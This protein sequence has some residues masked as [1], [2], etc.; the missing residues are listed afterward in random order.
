MNISNSLQK[1][2]KTFAKKLQVSV[3]KILIFF[4]SI[5]MCI[6]IFVSFIS[7]GYATFNIIIFI[8]AVIIEIFGFIRMYKYFN[9]IDIKYNT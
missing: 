5:S 2:I 3:L 1:N 6:A 8:V 4:I 7:S 9:C